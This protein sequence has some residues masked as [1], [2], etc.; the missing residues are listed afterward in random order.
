M[1]WMLKPIVDKQHWALKDVE[2]REDQIVGWA[3]TRW[4]DV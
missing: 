4:C 3:K 1:L 2:E